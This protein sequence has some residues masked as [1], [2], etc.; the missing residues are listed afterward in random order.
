MT[1][2]GL[3]DVLLPQFVA[4]PDDRDDHQLVALGLRTDVDPAAPVVLAAGVLARP[5][6][7]LR[8]LQRQLHLVLVDTHLGHSPSRVGR[9]LDRLP[10]DLHL[11]PPLRPDRQLVCRS[12]DFAVLEDDVLAVGRDR[13]DLQPLAD[14]DVDL[15][16]P[17][18][19][20][21]GEADDLLLELRPLVLHPE[22]LPGR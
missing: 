13:D 5:D 6:D 17:Q 12:C 11:S 8:V 7:G 20:A 15:E 14:G 22:F 16:D 18:P 2:A 3:L 9:Q 21:P 4:R 1:A 10:V 19:L